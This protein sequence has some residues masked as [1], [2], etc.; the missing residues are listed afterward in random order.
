MVY[1]LKHEDLTPPP[2]D[3][4]LQRS[5]ARDGIAATAIVVLAAVLVVMAIALL[6]P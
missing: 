4:Q 3:P 2:P 1:Q 6:L 5:V